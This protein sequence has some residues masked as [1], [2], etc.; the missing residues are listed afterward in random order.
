M[1]L[2]MGLFPHYSFTA[3]GQ[4]WGAFLMDLLRDKQGHLGLFPTGVQG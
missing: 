2:D 4:T 1:H 3:S